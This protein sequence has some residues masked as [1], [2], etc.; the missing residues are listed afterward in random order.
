MIQATL[1]FRH[2]S[3]GRDFRD[4]YCLPLTGSMFTFDF[5][6]EVSQDGLKLSSS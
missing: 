5:L 1:R 3:Q 6:S 2:K 4:L